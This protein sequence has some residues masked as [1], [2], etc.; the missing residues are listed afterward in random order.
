MASRLHDEKGCCNI[1]D[2]PGSVQRVNELVSADRRITGK[3]LSL[4][5]RIGEAS[6]CR[7]LKVLGPYIRSKNYGSDHKTWMDNIETH[8]SYSP[9]LAQS[10]HHLFGKQRI[11]SWNKV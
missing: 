10:D 2:S 8:P 4:Y 6:A 3:E 9:D 1:Q 11:S 7:I 5:I